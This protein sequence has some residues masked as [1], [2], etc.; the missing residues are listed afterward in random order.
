MYP[1]L[2]AIGPI[3]L[4]TYG[5]ML[6][7]AFWLGSGWLWREARRRGWD[8]NSIATLSLVLLLVSV[9]GARL[10]FVATHLSDYAHDPLGALRVWEGGLTLY[11]G[12]L[13]AIPAGILYCR[14]ARLPVWEVADAVAP[15]LA[16]GLALGRVGCFL[17]GCCY[18][19]PTTLPW[20]VRFPAHSYAALQF[21]G[22]ALHPSQLYF[23]AAELA[24]LGA[25]VA[26]RP[27]FPRPG[28]LWWLFVMLDSAT[29][30]LIDLT[31][32][33]EPSA[34][35]PGG[36][37]LSQAISIGLFLL[38]L[39]CFLAAGRAPARAPEHAAG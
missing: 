24:I 34:V 16:L 29:R 38:G 3:H 8:E 1:D 2:P 22:R 18:G 32:Y 9:I 17:N 20:G 33:Y 25:L 6:A 21:P 19:V 39:V 31:R 13:L 12:I 30:F 10:M 23:T 37:D 11:G 27:R 14:S 28:Q 36:V 5:L 26:L 35:L 7:L 4:H 15:A